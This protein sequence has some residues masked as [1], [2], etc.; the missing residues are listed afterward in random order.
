MVLC[1]EGGY[2]LNSIAYAMTMCSKTLLGDPLPMLECGSVASPSGI[3]SIRT[4]AATQQKYWS[5]LRFQVSH[6]NEYTKFLKVEKNGKFCGLT[7]HSNDNICIQIKMNFNFQTTL[8]FSLCKWFTILLQ[9]AL[10][11]EDDILL[12]Q[13]S[14]EDLTRMLAKVKLTEREISMNH[15]KDK[16]VNSMKSSKVFVDIGN[17]SD[18]AR[19][20]APDRSQ[21]GSSSSADGAG[22]SSS[23]EASAS[24]S[25]RGGDGSRQT[26]VDYLSDNMQVTEAVYIN[27]LLFLVRWVL[28][29]F[30]NASLWFKILT[31]ACGGKNVCCGSSV[32]L[33][34]LTKC[35]TSARDR[36]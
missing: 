30:N 19:S 21:Q 28:S 32:R 24:G 3:Q 8:F 9:V 18:Y 1:L 5:C 25:L 16:D 7:E 36:Y 23:G 10:P 2:N 33:S 35:R 34:S 26:L 13:E 31:D 11:Q 27:F 4:V 12:S 17:V 6:F 22:A 20:V 15:H 14:T 29:M